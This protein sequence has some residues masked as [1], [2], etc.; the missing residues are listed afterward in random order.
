MALDFNDCDGVKSITRAIGKGWALKISTFLGSN[1]TH[2]AC[3]HVRAQKGL[4]FLSP[5]LPMALVLDLPATTSS[6][7]APYK[8]QVH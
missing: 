7:T 1:G 3:C 5:P 8:Q 4:D 2:F 6:C